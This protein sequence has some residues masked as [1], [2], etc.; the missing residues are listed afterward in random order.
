MPPARRR[1]RVPQQ[2]PAEQHAEWL[3]LLAPDGPF[4]SVDVLVEAFGAGL[5][6]VGKERRD[7]VR[8]AWDEVQ[9]AP[10][11]LGSQWT[12][13]IL[14][15][16]LGWAAKY[17]TEPERHGS[18]P[19]PD[20]VLTG[21]GQR[22][23]REPRLLFYRLDWGSGVATSRADRPAPVE[24]AAAHCRRDGVPLALVTDGRLWALV[25]ARA[26]EPTSCGV[27][28][29]DLWLEEPLLLQAFAALLASERVQIPPVSRDGK[30]SSDST[31]ALFSRTAGAQGKL[32][33][34]LGLQVRQAVELLVG[35]L[36][37]LD[38]ESGGRLLAHIDERDI[39]R[40]A[41][42]VL[43]RMV[44]LLY[45]EEQRLLPTDDL[46]ADHY[47][48]TRLYDQLEEERNRYGD[49]V[50]DRRAAA[51]PRLL[52][53]F[54]G[55]HGGAEHPDLR[56]PAY[57]GSLFSPGRF[58]WLADFA[59]TDRV[60]FEILDAL[61]MLRGKRK[62]DAATRISYKG[63][64]VEDI[65]HIYEGLLEFSC[66][67]VDEPYVGLIGKLEP[68]LPLR[69]LEE[70]YREYSPMEE[71]GRKLLVEW[72][73]GETGATARQ[74]ERALDAEPT[75]EQRAALHAAGD[76]D[77]ELAERALPYWGLLRTDLRNDPTIFPTDSVLFTQVGERRK[78]GTHYTP[79]ALA[80]EV[81]EH[82]LAPLSYRPGPADGAEE[83]QWRVKPA[84]ELL[85]LKVC[86]PAMG[87]GAFLVSAVRYLADRVVEAWQRDGLPDDVL[88]AVGTRYELDE[89]RL[90][91]KRR[92]AAG[93]IY[94]VDRDD[95]AVE[96]AKLSLWLE[97][98]AKNKPFSFLDH[99]LRCGDSLVG[100]VS[101][102][103]VRTF[104]TDPGEGRRINNQI[105]GD[106]SEYIDRV[107]KDVTDLRTQIEE[108]PVVD[109]G[110]AERKTKLLDRA[111]EQSQRLKLAADAVIAAAL[112]ADRYTEVER[113]WVDGDAESK[114]LN[115]RE[116]YNDLLVNIAGDV[117]RLLGEDTYSFLEEE[118]LRER[119]TD[120]LTG[121]RDQP[122]RPLHWALEFPE[123]MGEGGFDA[124][125]GN[126]PFS[127][128]KRLT[129]TL[130]TDVREY[131]VVDIAGGKRGSADLCS[132]F[133]L[134]NLKI[135]PKGRTGIIATNTIAQGDTREVGLDQVTDRGWSIY[136][137][138]KSQVWPGTANVHVSLLWAG[139]A[140]EGEQ[141]VLDGTKV[142]GIT[143]SLDPRTRVTGKPWN[144]V[145]NADQA[146]QGSIVLGE[147]FILEPEEAQELIERDSRNREVLFPYLNGKDLNSRPD[148]SPSRWVIDFYDRTLEEAMSYPD[149]FE[150]V[151]NKVR[152]VRQRK[153]P[154]GEYVLRRPLPERW[155]QYADKRPTLRE[156]ITGLE[157]VLVIALMSRTAL[158][159]WQKTGQVFSHAL[160]V[161]SDQRD[162]MFSLLS[163]DIHYSWAVARAS[164]MKGD[165]RYTPTDVYETLPKPAFTSHMAAVGVELNEFRYRLLG[166]RQVGLTKLYNLVHDPDYA[167]G[168]IDRLREMHAQIDEAV[169]QAYGWL[170]LDLDH[171]HHETPQGVRWTISP[172]SRIE[173][174]DRL[175][176]L[177]FERHKEEER[178]GIFPPKKRKKRSA[179]SKKDDE[180]S[181]FPDGALFPPQGTMF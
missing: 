117:Q 174:L 57:G 92:V 28:D 40:G 11:L 95:M 125:V 178:K 29:A 177:N 141:P 112:A 76:S 27:F 65:G 169:K 34:E 49:E 136:R 107:L 175:L 38:R 100:L 159:V 43:M 153:K 145:A 12:E 115:W 8:Q 181:L 170:D 18:G 171:G 157:R 124:V 129:G 138:I 51:W 111:D 120:W 10:D 85:K 46:Y 154:N 70:R 63:L 103:Q 41:L 84:A 58:A 32:T 108:S 102:E 106:I 39:Y 74:L 77:A 89:L 123:V 167:D 24:Q 15:E 116:A 20:F 137:A 173:V 17:R 101:E 122:I 133:L 42:T 53:L 161:F 73:K 23:G 19:H 61:L 142:K 3:R 14:G 90:F 172:T 30:E 13:L 152:P 148:C 48:V 119:I 64:G 121:E 54:T 72:L 52:A 147:G 71:H 105:T 96:L 83:S 110:D 162:E 56:L 2:S 164:S 60:V 55:I 44:F 36:A 50:G 160:G 114:K 79:R 86:D 118:R 98:L 139:H 135:A 127:G 82:T 1:P 81:V 130:G 93:C 80:E 62:K 149:V 37:R 45:A 155:W 176:E 128:G 150:I 163:S 87:S 165:L 113:W 6:V 68:E 156:A 35:E 99:A 140:G 91:A 66:M 5:P 168:E 126:P 7:R 9:G 166:T 67:K 26:G 47:S 31:A 94:G 158:P 132:Y 69:V 21:P 144:L 146:F 88:E 109:Q 180:A 25:H 104:H 22:G 33:E 16:L 97:T 59:I 78:T 143:P 179:S 131:L 134:R 4:L 75:A 151:E